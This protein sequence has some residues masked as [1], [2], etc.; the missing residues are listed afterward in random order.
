MRVI[1][2]FINGAWQQRRFEQRTAW[3]TDYDWSQRQFR[4]YVD[5]SG[6]QI[7]QLPSGFTHS[8]FRGL[9]IPY[10]GTGWFWAATQ[11]IPGQTRST[12]GK[13]GYY[14]REPSAVQ[15][16]TI[17]QSTAGQQPSNPAG[18]AGP[19]GIAGQFFDNP[20]TG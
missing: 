13:E 18:T 2:G 5:A 12:G 6:A 10:R 4:H 14:P 16:N 1:N 9:R 3:T 19:G 20:M 8:R 11:I 7:V 17:S 15:L